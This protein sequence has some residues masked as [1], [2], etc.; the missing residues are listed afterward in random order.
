MKLP[1]LPLLLAVVLSGCTPQTYASG[2]CPNRLVGWRQP[3]EIGHQV[4]AIFITVGGEE[5]VTH[6]LWLG[7]RMT[8]VVVTDRRGLSELLS[9]A[10]VMDPRPMVILKPA[11]SA[12]C[13]LVNGVRGE[14]DTKLDCE[15]GQCGEG[16]GWYEMR[17][18][19]VIG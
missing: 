7:Y 12:T 5:A 10:A 4:P 15:S 17:G 6:T 11:P 16:S 8:P 1:S 13:A 18:M 3:G 9:H 19:P 14:M 2:Q